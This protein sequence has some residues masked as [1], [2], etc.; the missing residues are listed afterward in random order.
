MTTTAQMNRFVYAMHQQKMKRIRRQLT[1]PLPATTVRRMNVLKKAS[2]ASAAQRPTN[3]TI[4]TAATPSV[5]KSH[6]PAEMAVLI[7]GNSVILILTGMFFF[8]RTI[9]TANSGNPW[10]VLSLAAYQ[11]V[12][13]N[14]SVIPNVLDRK[15]VSM[16]KSRMMSTASIH[17]L[18]LF[19]LIRTLTRPMRQ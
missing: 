19:T 10:E 6:Q 3:S 1:A 9:L 2:C 7:Q 15:S 12:P 4:M 5:V 14:V 18:P 13:R 8:Q 11:A 16:P 17:V